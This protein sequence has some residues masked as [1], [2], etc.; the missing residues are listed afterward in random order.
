MFNK[1]IKSPLG[2]LELVN[3]D[4]AN[5]LEHLFKKAQFQDILEILKKPNQI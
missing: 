1:K 5:T 2:E 4:P 3:L